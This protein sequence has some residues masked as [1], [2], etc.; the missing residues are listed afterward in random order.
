[1]NTKTIGLAVLAAALTSS[2]L[3]QEA[4]TN[5]QFITIPREQY[6]LLKKLADEYPKLAEEMKEMKAFKAQAEVTLKKVAPQQAETDQALDELD[7]K[8]TDV[9]KLAKDSAPGTNK[10]LLTGYGSAGFTAQNRGGDKKFAATFNPIFLWKLSDRLLFEG[11]LEAELEGADTHLALEIAQMSYVLND[12]MTFGA[13]KFLNPA[14]YFVERQHMAWV[15][16]LPDKPL[17]VYDG[18][19]PESNLGMQLRGALPAGSMKF[20][21]AVYV[22]N[23]PMLMIDPATVAPS[24]FGKLE[25]NNFD[26]SDHHV[27]FGGRIGFQPFPELE[28]GYGM[29]YADVTPRGVGVNAIHALLQS[30]DFSYVRD[31]AV[32]CGTINLKGQWVWS[33]VSDFVYDPTSLAGGP[34]TFSN[35]REGGYVQLAYRPSRLDNPILKNLEG[36]VRADMLNQAKTAAGVDE[37]RL[38]F[39]LNYWL[40]PSSV[41]KVAYALDRQRGS[42]ADPHDTLMIQFATG[43]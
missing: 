42:N 34:Y 12:Y 11:E 30:L 14:N 21:Y 1:M 8:I 13:G 9:K 20:G 28:V 7:K 10:F 40:T 26:N 43:F 19:L 33:K 2:V 16:K 41:C 38:T 22:A 25:F 15:N 6:L 36:V 23:A 39:G 17:A 37:R 24:D 35:K 3:A 31:S 29:Q 32:L 4:G 18:L 5:S 27:A